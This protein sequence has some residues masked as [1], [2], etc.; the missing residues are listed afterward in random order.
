M[1]EGNTDWVDLTVHSVPYSDSVGFL[2]RIIKNKNVFIQ[3]KGKNQIFKYFVNYYCS[4]SERWLDKK[5]PFFLTSGGAC[6]SQS[7]NHLSACCQNPFSPLPV[8]GNNVGREK[9]TDDRP[10]DAAWGTE[11]ST[12]LGEESIILM[13]NKVIKGKSPSCCCS[14]RLTVGKAE[15]SFWRSQEGRGKLGKSHFYKVTFLMRPALSVSNV[16]GAV[17]P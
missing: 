11:S 10:N 12:F 3:Q 1:W 16:S 7:H 8:R 9:R 2:E 15:I 6:E 14:C 17:L 5:V 13:I 4:L